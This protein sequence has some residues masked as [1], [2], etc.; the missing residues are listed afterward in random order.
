MGYLIEHKEEKLD[1]CEPWEPGVG[2]TTYIEHTYYC[3]CC[4]EKVPDKRFSYC[5]WCGEKINKTMYKQGY[6]KKINKIAPQVLPTEE[7]PKELKA[8]WIYWAGWDGN[9]DKRIDGAVCSY[10][11][12]RHKT[13]Y[14]TPNNLAD[15]CPDCGRKMRKEGY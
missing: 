13:V 4:N 8:H 5:P 1:K 11:G 10:C 7:K 2:Y 15:Y 9:H 3:S 6:F 12:Y 14:N